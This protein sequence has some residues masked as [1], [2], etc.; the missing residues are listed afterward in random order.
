[1][2][3]GFS[4]CVWLSATSWPAGSNDD[5]TRSIQVKLEALV[6]AGLIKLW[7]YPLQRQPSPRPLALVSRMPRTSIIELDI[8][9]SKQ[10]HDGVVDL[11]NKYSGK[12]PSFIAA[13][14]EETVEFEGV[15]EFVNL[16]SQLWSLAVADHLRTPQI[17]ASSRSVSN[18]ETQ[19]SKYQYLASYAQPAFQRFLTS[20][21]PAGMSNLSVSDVI[22][23]RKYS[24]GVR[25]FVERALTQ[26]PLELN[27]HD[28][29]DSAAKRIEM[30]YMK[31]L[32]EEVLRSRP[33]ALAKVVGR[34]AIMTILGLISPILV[35][36]P[37][38]VDLWKWQQDV[39]KRESPL[40]F[41]LELRNR[42][43]SNESMLPT[44]GVHGPPTERS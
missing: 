14:H 5:S 33:S 32:E 8:D 36:V 25:E 11:I 21:F 37:W 42:A 30:E 38:L 34:N 20:K 23:L 22:R 10:M 39:Q 19:L 28:H 31:L 16:S 35:A 44:V 15:S 12:L 17:V 41:M 24:R 1:M 43:H 2:L 6:E 27:V 18:F 13:G 4:D 3:L 26:G 40:Y 9:L 7:S 29:V